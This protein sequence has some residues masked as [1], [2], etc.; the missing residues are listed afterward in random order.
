[1]TGLTDLAFA[2]E[3]RPNIVVSRDSGGRLEAR[4]RSYIQE[5]VCLPLN[6]ADEDQAVSGL[7][8]TF[9]LRI[10]SENV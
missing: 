2:S 5:Q 4:Q 8:L 1:M 7:G 6:A 10:E 3:Q 9:V